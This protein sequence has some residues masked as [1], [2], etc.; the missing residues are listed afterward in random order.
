MSRG[1]DWGIREWAEENR[2]K[3]I[4]VSP[5]LSWPPEK[6]DSTTPII[7]DNLV[8]I[9]SAEWENTSMRYQRM[10]AHLRGLGRS[11]AAPRS[12]T[13]SLGEAK[14]KA[15]AIDPVQ[16]AAVTEVVAM[17]LAGEVPPSTVRLP[18]RSGHPDAPGRCLGT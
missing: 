11:S 16:A 6:G 18:G 13:G 3:L 5:E 15:L 9:A 8:N 10:Q 12:A 17:Y 1:R 4:V 14:S 7:W 2:K